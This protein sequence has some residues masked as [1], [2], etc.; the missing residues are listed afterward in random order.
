MAQTAAHLVEQVIPWV[1][2]RQ[3]AVSV[4]VPLRYWMAASQELTA[5]VHTIIRTTIGQYYVH[6]AVTGGI[7]RDQVHPGSVTFI[8]RF[9]S[10]L[11]LKVFDV[12]CIYFSEPLSFLLARLSHG[13]GS[14]VLIPLG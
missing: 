13:V 3:G 12:D 8:Q 2:T 10:A 6:Q 7:P 14:R 11:N 4:P 1:P 9:G 5:Q